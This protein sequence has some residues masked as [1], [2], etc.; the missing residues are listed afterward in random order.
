MLIQRKFCRVCSLAENSMKCISKLA[1][2]K[3]TFHSNQSFV[4]S[5]LVFSKVMKFWK[6]RQNRLNFSDG[7]QNVE[8]T[9][10][11]D[12]SKHFGVIF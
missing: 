6:G 10:N 8:I 3:R 9:K 12:G 1:P 11:V 4:Q 7:Q 2:P 5:C